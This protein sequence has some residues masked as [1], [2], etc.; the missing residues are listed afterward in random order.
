MKRIVPELTSVVA[1]DN[2]GHGMVIIIR[3]ISSPGCGCDYRCVVLDEFGAD[4]ACIC[5]DGSRLKKDNLTACESKL[6]DHMILA[7]I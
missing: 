5:P 1:G 3:A 6:D 7:H 4:V 2:S